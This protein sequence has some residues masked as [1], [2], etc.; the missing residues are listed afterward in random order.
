[1]ERIVNADDFG[2]YDGQNLAVERA[3]REG[4]LN[5]ASLMTTTPGFRQAVGIARANPGLRVGV[6]LTL[7]ETPPALPP[8]RLG[9][10]V[11]KNGCFPDR[12]GTILRAWLSGGLRFEDIRAEWTHQ[13][14]LALAEGIAPAHLDSHKHVHLLPP[15]MEIAIALALEYGITYVRLP[16]ESRG[17]GRLRRLP[18]ALVLRFLSERARRTLAGASLRHADDFY[19]FAWSGRMTAP[20]LAQALAGARRGRVTEIMVHPAVRT[21]D[22]RSLQTRYRWAAAYLFEEELAALIEMRARMDITR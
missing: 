10:L 3:H 17:H 12:P 7:N 11:R 6:H 16:R 9:G 8:D 13:I 21:P 22:V 1:M 15:L 2:W 14:A 18:F 20:R 19:G 4:I 5:S